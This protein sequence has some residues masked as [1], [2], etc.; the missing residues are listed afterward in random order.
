[1]YVRRNLGRRFLV[2]LLAATA[3]LF[4]SAGVASAA[5]VES[6][7]ERVTQAAN[8]R[9]VSLTQVSTN[10][11]LDAHE[12]GGDLDFNVVTRPFQNNNTQKWW[13]TDL[14]NGLYRISQA[15]SGRYVDAHEYADADYRVV[16]RTL[17]DNP[18]QVWLL[19]EVDGKYSIQQVSS[20]RYLDAHQSASKDYRAVTR[21]KST[22]DN[23]LW[24]ITNV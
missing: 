6:N 9:L 1:M 11:F 23:Q 22:S 7:T 24:R 10:R 19:R 8:P 14:G 17:Q 4:G 15:S 3:L 13:L 12:A 21:P 5:P 16:T 20:G 18:T 2:P